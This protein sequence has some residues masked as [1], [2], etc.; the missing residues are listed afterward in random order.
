[1]VLRPQACLDNLT[2]KEP[3]YD[4]HKKRGQLSLTPTAWAILSTLAK[5]AGLSRSEFIERLAR[6]ELSLIDG[7]VIQKTPS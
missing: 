2:P 5:K 7:E 6:A 3:F 4:E 1:M